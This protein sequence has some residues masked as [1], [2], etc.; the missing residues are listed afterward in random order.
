VIRRQRDLPSG[1]DSRNSMRSNIGSIA[2][3]KL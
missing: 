1:F 3:A 2:S